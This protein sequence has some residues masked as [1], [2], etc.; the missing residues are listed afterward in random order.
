MAPLTDSV[1]AD[2]A[3]ALAWLMER[4]AAQVIRLLQMK[5]KAEKLRE[6]TFLHFLKVNEHQLFRAGEE[7][8]KQARELIL[9]LEKQKREQ[10]LI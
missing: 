3:L 10:R 7:S 8:N 1:Q 9:F 4:R 2:P 6:F 5:S